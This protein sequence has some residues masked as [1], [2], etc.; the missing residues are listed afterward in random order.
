MPSARGGHKV[1]PVKS[2]Q[3]DVVEVSH[4]PFIPA[5][6]TRRNTD[7]RAGILKPSFLSRNSSETKLAGPLTSP[8]LVVREPSLQRFGTAVSQTDQ[9]DRS[10]DTMRTETELEKSDTTSHA[11]SN[12]PARPLQPAAMANDP[13]WPLRPAP[14]R[15]PSSQSI[16][17]DDT[18]EAVLEGCEHLTVEDAQ[19]S[20]S[21]SHSRDAAS[22]FFSDSTSIYSS[23][24]SVYSSG[25]S[26]Y[27]LEEETDATFDSRLPGA[28]RH[29]QRTRTVAGK[30][31]E[32]QSAAS[33]ERST[34]AR[35]AAMFK[36]SRLR[37]D[38]PS[39]NTSLP[40]W[41]MVCRAAQASL[42]CYDS[43]ALTRQGTYTPAD[44][45]KDIKAMIIDDQFIDDSRVIIVSIRGTQFQCLSDWAVNK[46]ANPVPP[47]GFLDDEGNACHAGFLQVTKAMVAQVAAQLQQHPAFSERPSLLFT[48]HSAGGAVAAMLYSHMLSSSVESDLTVLASH[49]ASINCVTFGAP[50]LSLTPLPRR[51]HASGVF[52]AFANEGDPVLRLSNGSYVKSLAKLMTASPPPASGPTPAAAQPVKVVRQSR[53]TRVIR[54]IVPAAP[55]TPWEELPLWP[56]PPAPLTNAGDVVLLR[57]EEN[58]SAVASQVLHEDLREVIFG[59]LAQHTI[60]MYIRRVKEV[61]FAAM[62]GRSLN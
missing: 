14:S 48:G 12:E 49:F 18:Y 29:Q 33:R 50:P 40:T 38:L 43:Q 57:D 36:N 53:G 51:D 11:L 58:G 6:P 44:A 56:T 54:Q 52:L 39:F 3:V 21:S 9:P 59:D 45:A 42:D 24:S 28:S 7:W 47:V 19:S 60:E 61:A 16:G 5:K 35:K 46:A 31:P 1:K 22:T 25:T 20:A 55:P 10:D 2:I 23:A 62:I 15:N 32:P 17:V 34:L 27:S 4:V 13:E 41:S 26:I 30:R 37:P 8:P